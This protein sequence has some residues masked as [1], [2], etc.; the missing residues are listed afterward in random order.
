[1]KISALSSGSFANAFY[2]EDG[3][4][5]IL[6]DD[7]LSFK[8]INQRLNS[9]KRSPDKI[10]AIFV[11]HEHSDHIRG[12]DVLSRQLNIPIYL[13]K[14]TAKKAFICSEESLINYIKNNESLD[15]NGI[16][17]TAFSKSHDCGDPVSYILESKKDK[18]TAGIITDIGYPCKNVTENISDS[19]FLFIEANHDENMLKNGPYPYFLKKRI[20]SDKGHLSNYQSA[21]SVLEHGN[22]KLKAVVLS[23]LSETNNTPDVASK[24][25]KKIIKE[26]SDLKPRVFVSTKDRATPLFDI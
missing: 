25:Y 11:T 2:V 21:V 24:T 19:D 3:D 26:R 15:I 16:K 9:I 20:L 4:H 13:T 6:I 14:A 7:G 1:M 23:H 22:P 18:K 12:V 10:N 5:A 17:I 8:E